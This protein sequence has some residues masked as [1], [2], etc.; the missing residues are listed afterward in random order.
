MT[1]CKLSK[2]VLLP[3]L[4][5]KM[6]A[7]NATIDMLAEA[8]GLSRGCVINARD[9]KGVYRNNALCIM[10]TLN[11]RSFTVNKPGPKSGRRINK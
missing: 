1:K 9:G 3:C 8:S 11:T 6:E 2:Y 5:A 7:C 4:K 10:E